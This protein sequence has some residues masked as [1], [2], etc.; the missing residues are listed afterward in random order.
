MALDSEKNEECSF[1]LSM[2]IQYAEMKTLWHSY[3][4]K[5]YLKNTQLIY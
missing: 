3:I 4:Y 5:I 1:F 2:F